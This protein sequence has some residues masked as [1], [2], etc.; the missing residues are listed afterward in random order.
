MQATL[1]PCQGVAGLR[2]MDQMA[3]ALDPI[4]DAHGGE[5]I[6]SLRPLIEH[7]WYELFGT[8]LR[9]PVLSRCAA[10]IASDEPWQLALWS[11]DGP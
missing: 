4:A 2:L 1:I 10:L 11:N 3:K 7:A 6:G 8:P 9:E 5:P